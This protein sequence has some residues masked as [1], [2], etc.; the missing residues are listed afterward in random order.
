MALTNTTPVRNTVGNRQRVSLASTF[1]S[2]YATGGEAFNANAICGLQVVESVQISPSAGYVAEYV[3]SAT[4]ASR[5][6]KVY[7]VD[8]S[9]DGSPLLEVASTTNLS[10]VTF[11]VVVNGY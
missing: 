7:W 8:T 9:I 3:P 11:N 5:K 4:A 1:D 10:A 6:I 2:S